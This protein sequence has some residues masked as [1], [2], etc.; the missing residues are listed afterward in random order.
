MRGE[1]IQD[2][3]SSAL[4]YFPGEVS[5]KCNY[6]SLFIHILRLLMLPFFL[7]CRKASDFLSLMVNGKEGTTA[8]WSSAG[9]LPP[10]WLHFI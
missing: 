8:W 2:K 3:I 5:L 10:K 9:S 1:D 4:P 6:L 7:H